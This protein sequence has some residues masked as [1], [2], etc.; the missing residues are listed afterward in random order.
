[1]ATIATCSK[2]AIMH[3]IN[4]MT[5]NT[6]AWRTVDFFHRLG[7]ATVTMHVGMLAIQFKLRLGIMIEPPYF[8]AVRGMAFLAVLT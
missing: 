4:A 3:I 5:A 1:M 2:L 7:M 6:G 8:P